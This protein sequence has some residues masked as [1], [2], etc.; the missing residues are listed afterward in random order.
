[1]ENR[2]LYVGLDIGTT[3]IKVIVAESVQGQ[4]NII[5]VGSQRSSGLSRGIIV[6]IDKVASAIQSAVAQAEEKAA[7][8]IAS[9]VAG[10]PA[11]MLQIESVNGMIAVGDQSKEITDADVQAVAAAALVRNL[12]PE[13]AT[14]SLVPT[15]FIVDGFDGIKDPRNM[16]GVR[17][18]MHGILFTVPKTVLHNTKKAIEKAGLKIQCL[19]VDPLAA[20]QVALT[21][22]EQDFGTVLIDLGGGQTTASVIHDHKLKLATVDPEGGEYVTKDIS[23]VLNTDLK[24]AEKL[25]R[26]YGTADS[27]AAKADNSFPVTVVGKTEPAL[28]SEKYL[29]EIIEARL[30]QVF[31]RLKQQLDQAHALDLPGGIVITGGTTALPGTVA[32]AEDIFSA[33]RDQAVRVKRFVP[34]EM[35]LRHPAFTQALGLITYAAQMTDIDA[36]VAS[37]LPTPIDIAKPIQPSKPTKVASAPQAAQ[38]DEPDAPV[39]KKP[40]I[41]HRFFDNFFE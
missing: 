8:K 35:G 20:A 19:V 36:L 13:R 11:N 32:L 27:L 10:V 28:I 24:D 22:A 21:D 2:A 12:P 33:E 5:G 16:V 15:E 29:A 25:K 1:M 30:T 9:V 17:L 6:D 4:L 26:D 40:G 41:F 7:I 39:D 23:V 34:D 38:P 18:E 14:L 3:S 37:V 31:N